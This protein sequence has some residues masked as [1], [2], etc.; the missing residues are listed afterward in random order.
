MAAFVSS[1]IACDCDSPVPPL[2][3]GVEVVGVVAAGVLVV[4]FGVVVLSGMLG[5]LAVVNGS[6][7]LTVVG[8]PSLGTAGG[9]TTVAPGAAAAGGVACATVRVTPTVRPLPLSSAA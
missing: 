5:G 1:R 7:G 8:V 6:A 4:V 3:A 2:P 9:G